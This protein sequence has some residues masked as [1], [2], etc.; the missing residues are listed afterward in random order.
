M[1]IYFKSK[2]Q[3]KFRLVWLKHHWKIAK[4]GENFLL[5]ERNFCLRAVFPK[6]FLSF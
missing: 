6:K 1:V 5:S 2:S 4:L 3:I